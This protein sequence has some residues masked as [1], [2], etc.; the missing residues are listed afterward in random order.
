MILGSD[1]SQCV[2]LIAMALKIILGNSAKHASKA[3]LD[4]R[5]FFYIG[6]SQKVFADGRAFCVGHFLDAY[7]QH[8][9]SAFGL[10]RLNALINGGTAGRASVLNS[11]R[12]G[13]AECVIGL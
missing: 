11:G 5:L 7:Y 12:R 1:F 13:K 10:D 4:I 3:A 9:T 8:E 6:C 2:R